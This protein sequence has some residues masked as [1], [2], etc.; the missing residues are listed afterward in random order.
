MILR[1]V[2]Q[3]RLIGLYAGV[4][5]VGILIVGFLFNAIGL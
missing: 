1:R 4:V 2:I 5:I 3:P